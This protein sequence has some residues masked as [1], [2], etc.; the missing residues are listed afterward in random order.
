M[1]VK[2]KINTQFNMGISTSCPGVIG[3]RCY[4]PFLKKIQV[5]TLKM[6][7]QTYLYVNLLICL[8][9]FHRINLVKSRKVIPYNNHQS[10]KYSMTTSENVFGDKGTI[11]YFQDLSYSLNCSKLPL[12]LFLQI[13]GGNRCVVHLALPNRLLPE[14]KVCPTPRFIAGKIYI[15]YILLGLVNGWSAATSFLFPVL[16][17]KKMQ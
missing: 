12:K 17:T 10:V 16:H 2:E 6:L 13:N 11:Y 5:S 14:D 7:L 1:N 4:S 15:R 8:A 9:K 3:F